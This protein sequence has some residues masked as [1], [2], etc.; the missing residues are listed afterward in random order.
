MVLRSDEGTG[1]AGHSGVRGRPDVV[2]CDVL[3]VGSSRIGSSLDRSSRSVKDLER[4]L[5]DKEPRLDLKGSDTIQLDVSA[6]RWVTLS[7]DA[8]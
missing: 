6:L 1:E 4:I 3:G 7:G 2:R 8:K 5:D